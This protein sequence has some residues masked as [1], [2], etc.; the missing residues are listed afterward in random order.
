MLEDVLRAQPSSVAQLIE[1]R[2]IGPAF[3]EK[4]G[5][6]LI[7]TLAELDDAERAAVVDAPS[8]AGEQPRAAGSPLASPAAPT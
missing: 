2:G 3:C 6:S 1:I 8:G 4:H 5:E 7:A